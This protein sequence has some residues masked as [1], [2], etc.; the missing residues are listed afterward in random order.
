VGELAVEPYID[1]SWWDP[2]SRK[3]REVTVP[4]DGEVL[5]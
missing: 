5:P 2:C 3:R 4:S 1:A